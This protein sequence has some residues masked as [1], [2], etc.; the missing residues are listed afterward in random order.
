MRGTRGQR[1]YGRS[2]VNV[3]LLGVLTALAVL[4]VL[5]AHGSSASAAPAAPGGDDF[6]IEVVEDYYLLGPGQ[7]GRRKF[8]VGLTAG[9]ALGVTLTVD[10]TDLRGVVKIGEDNCPEDPD[11]AYVFRCEVGTVDGLEPVLPIEV[12]TAKGAR[13]GDHGTVRYSATA[14]GGRSVT[15]TSRMWIGP[16]I[17]GLREREEKPVRGVEPGSTVAF[18]PAFRNDSSIT[19]RQLGLTVTTTGLE[20]LRQYG[21]CRYSE[22][23]RRPEDTPATVKY[24]VDCRFEEDAAV[25]P[26]RAYEPG[27]PLRFRVPESL[28]TTALRY[29]FWLPGDEHSP[30]LEGHG[31]LRER[32]AG[33]GEAVEL[34]PA[35]GAAEYPKHGRDEVIV[36]T[37]GGTDLQAVAETVEGRVGDVVKIEL[38]ARSD[39]PGDI[40]QN[41]VQLAGSDAGLSYEIVPPPG[42]ILDPDFDEDASESGWVC[43]DTRPGLDRYVCWVDATFLAG[44]E[45][46]ASFYLRIDERVDGAEGHVRVLGGD[47]EAYPAH[48]PDP[49]NDTAA[50]PVEITGSGG[51]AV[52]GGY[53]GVND[54]SAIDTSADGTPGTRAIAAGVVVLVLLVLL[55][56]RRRHAAIRTIRRLRSNGS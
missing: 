4:A 55:G 36:S 49:A 14:D 44:E 9:H 20:P 23:T 38:G 34:Q 7:G 41:A 25:A 45:Q 11:R 29:D 17:S 32:P 3:A 46:T 37:T 27:Q 56:V 21:N 5:P 2:A 10:A 16:G 48:D 24:A 33:S 22:P 8:E 52:P 1:R 19:P 12:S 50:I 54:L 26:G 39:G 6:G 15:A 51:T 43:D 53:S 42:T 28:M 40:T 18:T 30:P 13:P 35:V 31:S 47:S